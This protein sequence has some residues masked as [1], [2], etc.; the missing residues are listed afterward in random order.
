MKLLLTS[1]GI[2]NKSLASAL[3]ELIGKPFEESSIVFIPTASNVEKGDKGWFIDNLVQLQKL[4]FKQID[5]ADISAVPMSV[6]K[7]KLEEAD[8][9]F[10]EGGNTYHLMEQINKSGLTNLLP[11]LLKN[12]VYV[13]V[14]A[15]SMVTGPNLALS[16]S[17]ILYKDD[18]DRT[19]EMDGLKYVDFYFLP[20]L[21]SEY[22]VNLRKKNIEEAIKGMTTKVYA[23]DDACGIKIVDGKIKVISEGEYLEFN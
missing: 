7:P 15:G 21:N 17:Q 3:L 11:E 6:W 20:H 1:A 13:G 9:I 12:R 19:K 4:N 10:F 8:V 18:L 23:L 14:S 5:I 22:F 2:T 16:I